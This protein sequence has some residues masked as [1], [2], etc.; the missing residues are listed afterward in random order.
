MRVVAER[1]ALQLSRI[2]ISCQLSD[3]NLDQPCSVAA[4]PQPPCWPTFLLN[5]HYP[6]STLLRST[7]HLE[8]C[9]L[10]ATLLKETLVLAWK[11]LSPANGSTTDTGSFPST[12]RGRHP[13]HPPF[14][15]LLH[16]IP[17]NCI[18]VP[19]RKTF[20]THRLRT[21]LPLRCMRPHWLPR[22]RT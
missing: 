4:L 15:T 14:K 1:D 6:L 10:L 18:D 5:H 22:Y 8:P 11:I 17:L 12:L 16:A 2:Q 21:R 3:S 7:A 9:L 20:P 19:P 13:R